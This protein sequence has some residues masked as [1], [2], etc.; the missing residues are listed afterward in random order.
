[1]NFKLCNPINSQ[2]TE[3][4]LINLSLT[5]LESKLNNLNSTQAY[6]NEIGLG[7]G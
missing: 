1:M 2:L 4:N 5:R 6:S 3:F 7:L